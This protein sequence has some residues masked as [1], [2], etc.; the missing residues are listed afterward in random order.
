[1]VARLLLV[2]LGAQ[3]VAVAM[4]PQRLSPVHLSP[5]QAVVLGITLAEHLLVALAVAV[6]PHL[7]LQAQPT[8]AAV[9]VVG[10][11]AQTQAQAV[12]A[13]SS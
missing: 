10:M 7:L 8:Q 13:S 2:L 1:M 5:T 11:A 12:Q 4:E 9:V 3:E 6:I